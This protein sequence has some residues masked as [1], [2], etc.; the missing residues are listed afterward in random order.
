MV[1]KTGH[2][3]VAQV[4]F[5]CM[6]EI[7]LVSFY[8]RFVFPTKVQHQCS[9]EN[10]VFMPLDPWKCAFLSYFFGHLLFLYILNIESK[11]QEVEK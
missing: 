7:V 9:P 4:G 6:Q 5:G 8:D 2:R 11:L 3:A 10:P 1:E